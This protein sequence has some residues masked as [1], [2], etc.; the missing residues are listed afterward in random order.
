MK[1]APKIST[2]IIWSDSIRLSEDITTR[3]S[4]QSEKKRKKSTSF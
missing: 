2:K 1:M 3:V 4:V